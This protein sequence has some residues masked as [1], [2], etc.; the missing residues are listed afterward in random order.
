MPKP[1]TRPQLTQAEVR[2]LFAY[3]EDGYLVWRVR[4]NKATKIG[5]RAGTTKGNDKGYL[6]IKVHGWE[7]AVHRLVYLWHTGESPTIV[8]H[9]D[10][11]RQ[12]NK[13]SNLRSAS[14][15]HN[16]WNAVLR[17]DAQIKVKGVTY[18]EGKKSPWVAELRVNGKR[19]L[20]KSFQ[21]LEEAERAVKEARRIY[22][23]GFHEDG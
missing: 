15:S 17:K 7:Y 21:T 23:K 12:N 5:E 2:K 8:D 1:K 19:V 20:H 16:S 14:F 9:I 11:N 6:R 18:R 22:H 13:I 10:H 4:L 3:H